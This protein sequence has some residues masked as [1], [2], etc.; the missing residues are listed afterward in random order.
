VLLWGQQVIELYDDCARR[1][2]ATI[3]A[4]K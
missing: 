4:L 2:D 1:H 3:D